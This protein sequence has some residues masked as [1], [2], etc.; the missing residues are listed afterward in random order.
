[1]KTHLLI[2]AAIGLS[3]ARLFAAETFQEA[4]IGG[5]DSRVQVVFVHPEN[6]N[7][8]RDGSFSTDKGEAEILGDLGKFIAAT[9]DAVLPAGYKVKL[10]F[11]DI[12]LAGWINP[13]S[14]G[15][16]DV[17]VIK[18]DYPPAFRF[19]YS[20]TD[21]TGKIVKQGEAN[22]RD[23]DYKDRFASAVYEEQTRPYEKSVL[24]DWLRT[25]LRG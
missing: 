17:R 7:D 12:T 11:T 3:T 5:P 4:N 20:I 10:E 16:Q 14:G 9:S 22:V 19:N 1:M 25:N 21:A 13:Q 24:K 23:I 6:F 15:A 8:I 2:A 18:S